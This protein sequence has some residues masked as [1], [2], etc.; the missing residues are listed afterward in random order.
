MIWQTVLYFISI[1]LTCILTGFL[2]WYVWRQPALPGTRYF[3]QMVISGFL[4]SLTE[5][6]SILSG[7]Q[8]QALA[9]FNLR[10][11]FTASIPILW[12][13]FALEYNGR[14]DW[15]SNRLMSGMFIIPLI[16]Q[17]LIWNSSLHGLWVKQ[18]VAFHQSG[19]FWIAETSARIPG[20]WFMVHSFY[21]MILLLTGVGVILFASIG[22]QWK[23]RWQ[24][25]LLSAG[26]L[27]SLVTTVVP[28]FN[29]FPQFE[30]NPFVPGLGVSALFYFLA[31][32]RFQF[33]E[34]RPN[35]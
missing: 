2:D 26:V 29:I 18:E 20:L 4:L 23:Y 8:A 3:A 33:F 25:I 9:W 11:I 12:L 30:F 1:L 32:F 10:F 31:I 19:S 24:G 17:V 28:V 21:S 6:F 35:L 22:K 5:V 16:T 15:L 27:I 14:R 34:T 13:F 7:T